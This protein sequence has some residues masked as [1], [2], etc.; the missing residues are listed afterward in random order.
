MPVA[1]AAPPSTPSAPPSVKSF[2]T[3]MTKRALA[4]PST[5]VVGE[6][7][8]ASEDPCRQQVEGG[9]RVVLD[10]GADG[11]ERE[12]QARAVARADHSGERVGRVDP[13]GL[14]GHGTAC[15]G[16]VPR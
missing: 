2:C 16:G 3:S 10:A 7:V 12:R 1:T 15:D 8:P 11:V 13:T 6:V 5:L 14:R 4:M 9:F